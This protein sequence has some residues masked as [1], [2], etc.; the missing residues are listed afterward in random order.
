M[1]SS[2]K[3][4]VRKLWFICICFVSFAFVCSEMYKIIYLMFALCNVIDLA[5]CRL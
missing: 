4:N 3:I 2:E 5:E 1:T